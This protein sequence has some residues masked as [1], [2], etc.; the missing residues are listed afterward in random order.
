CGRLVLPHGEDF[1][2]A[3][4]LQVHTRR[5]GA[6]A[7]DDSRDL[8]GGATGRA[9]LAAKGFHQAPIAALKSL[10]LLMILSA[11]FALTSRKVWPSLMPPCASRKVLAFFA[12]SASARRSASFIF[13]SSVAMAGPVVVAPGWPAGAVVTGVATT[14][15]AS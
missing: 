11:V 9:V 2:P 5:V 1:G 10:N 8:G 13:W 7:L 14:S 12:S 4:S 3:G 15:R 6:E